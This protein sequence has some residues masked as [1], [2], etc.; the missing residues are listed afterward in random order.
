MR[1]PPLGE[2]STH[3]L[4]SGW[5][6]TSLTRA[7]GEPSAQEER[8]CQVCDDPLFGSQKKFCSAK[9]QKLQGRDKYLQDTYGITLKEWEGLYEFQGGACAICDRKPTGARRLVVDHE[10]N[11][12]PSG[13]VRGLICNIPCNLRII[14]KHKTGDVLRRAADYLDNPPATRYFE[15]ERI[16]PGR[17]KRVRAVRRRTRKPKL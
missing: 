5:R 16:A 2:P 1:R 12:G 10:H 13:K 3:G 6:N 11:G 17:K 7:R 9:C 15:E 14:A 4:T 8:I